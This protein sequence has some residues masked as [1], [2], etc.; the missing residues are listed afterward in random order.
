[1]TR[2]LRPKVLVTGAAGVMGARL[3]RGLVDAGWEVRGLVLPGDP[4]R[5]RLEGCGCEIREGDVSVADS[6]D[7][8][9]DGIDTV[10]HLAAVILSH[11]PRVFRRVNLDGTVNLVRAA[12]AANVRHF[13]YVSS[14]S[15]TYPRRTPYAESKLAAETCVAGERAFEHTIVRPTLAYDENGGQEFLLF[16]S[17]LRRFPVVPFIGRGTARKRPVHAG[18]IVDGLLRLAH[19][20]VS[21]GKTYNFSGAESISMIDFARLMLEHHGVKKRFVHVPLVVCRAIARALEVF[22]SRPA[23]TTSAIAGI[24]HDAD[25]DPAEAMR[26]LGYRPI[27]VREGFQRCFPRTEPA[28]ESSSIHLS[29]TE[30]H[31]R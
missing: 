7:G 26:D 5:S 9:C 2:P 6:L 15:V 1:M 21:Y 29:L 31:S 12:R 10:Y 30:R 23:L 19:Q 27:G 18:D 8:A 3:V 16:L 20:P 28:P 11:D 25:L 22:S 14:A 4:L 24:V 13:V 17:Y